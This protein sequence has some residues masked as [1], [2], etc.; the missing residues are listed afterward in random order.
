M[1]VFSAYSLSY[2]NGRDPEPAK[3][4]E[5]SHPT[6]LARTDNPTIAPPPMNTKE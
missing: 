1:V 5:P 6:I 3:V 2:C 4:T